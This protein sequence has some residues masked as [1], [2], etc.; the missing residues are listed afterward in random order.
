MKK[1][2]KELE[3]TC[4]SCGNKGILKITIEEVEKEK[5]EKQS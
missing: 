3:H 2:T 1:I 5:D 4:E